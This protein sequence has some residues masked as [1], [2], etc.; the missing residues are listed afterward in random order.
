MASALLAGLTVLVIGDSHLSMP[1]YLI[2]SLHDG[3]TQQGAQVHSLAACGIPAG[4]WVNLAPATCGAERVGMET[5][6]IIC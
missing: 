2:R 4:D 3:I 1:T 5:P 6:T